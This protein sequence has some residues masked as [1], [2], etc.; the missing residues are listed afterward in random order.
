MV[1]QAA[2][3]QTFCAAQSNHFLIQIKEVRHSP[4]ILRICKFLLKSI[5]LILRVSLYP[6]SQ[7]PS[8]HTLSR[9]RQPSIQHQQHHPTNYQ[10]TSKKLIWMNLK[11]TNL[12]APEAIAYLLP[13]DC[14]SIPSLQRATLNKN[15]ECQ[16]L[17]PLK[18]KR[19]SQQMIEPL[20]DCISK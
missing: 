3:A 10:S 11:R 7:Q 4:C 14:T 16:K 1:S 15:L 9:S 13:R 18:S 20:A 19:R 12:F 2:F 6:T 17:R 5:K 8:H